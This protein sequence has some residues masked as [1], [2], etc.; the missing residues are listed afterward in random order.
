M[1]ANRACVTY[2]LV[3]AKISTRATRSEE[4]IIHGNVLSIF[5][6]HFEWFS[7]QRGFIYLCSIALAI[8]IAALS[9]F[10]LC[11]N[12]TSRSF[13]VSV[14][15]AQMYCLSVDRKKLLS[16]YC[17]GCTCLWIICSMK[18]SIVLSDVSCFFT[19]VDAVTAT[20]STGV[21]F[22]TSSPSACCKNIAVFS[23]LE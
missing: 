7:F 10:F 4:E 3:S 2:D 8:L 11:R 21:I 15:I 13:I 6:N 14:T 18:Y 16:L 22:F 5:L 20:S 9:L 19:A 1:P 17:K 12:T 23:R